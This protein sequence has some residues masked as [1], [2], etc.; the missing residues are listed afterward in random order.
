MHGYLASSPDSS[1]VSTADPALRLVHSD[2]RLIDGA[3]APLGL[4]LLDALEA[5]AAEREGLTRGDAFAVLLRRNLVTGATVVL[6]RD[7]L[8]SA[9]PIGADWIHDEWLAMIAAALDA[10]PGAFGSSQSR[11]ST[12]D[13]TAE[14]RSGRADRPWP[15]VGRAC[16]NHVSSGRRA[17]SA[18]HGNWPSVC[19]N[20]A[21]PTVDSSRR[22]T[23]LAHEARRAGPAARAARAGTAGGRPRRA[24][25]LPSLQS[26]LDRCPA[27]SRAAGREEGA[28]TRVLVL[29]GDP[30]GERM[31]GPAIR[32]WNI[33]LELLANGH[34]VR[35]VSTAAAKRDAT[36]VTL[37]QVRPGDDRAFRTHERWAEVIVVQGYGLGQFASLRRTDRYL[38]VDAYDPIH[39]ELLE[40]GREL[41][42]ATWKHRVA[43][44]RDALNDQLRRADLVLC[45]SERQRLFYLG[46]LA[47]LGRINPATYVDDPQLERLLALVPF[48]LEADPPRPAPAI[49]DVVPGV[50]SDSRILIWG[51]GVYDWFDPLT[52]IRAVAALAQRMPELR[53]FFLGTRH[54]RVDDMGIVRDSYD[55]AVALGVEGRQVIFNDQWV[56]YDERGAYLLEADL[57]V[58]THHVHVETEFAFRTRILDYLWA[59]LP[60]V[61]T[62]GDGFAELVRDEELGIVVPPED[63]IALASA[64]ET[65]LT[66]AGAVARARS[67]VARVRDRFTWSV[68]VAPLV[69]FVAAPRHA[70]DYVAGRGGMGAAGPRPARTAGPLHDLRM[71]LHHLRHSGPREVLRRIRS[72]RRPATGQ[73]ADDGS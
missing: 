56:P 18:E 22:G 49:R 4:T 3:G 69:S 61:V 25:P 67:G 59:G 21:C 71:S 57:G 70:S 8:T 16:G 32:A 34:E 33:S 62:D 46:H 13:S 54:P 1:R 63:E 35:L 47:S 41:P 15:T 60:M 27:R 2:A 10:H 7:L 12:T 73:R 42:D 64:I 11:S 19:A 55:L 66:D 44:A 39:L 72:R 48:G 6:R 14:T 38:V 68:V 5:T 36:P 28:M 9:L 30:V 24:R 43:V 20:S 53:M 26:G 58:S 45:A 23:R 29:T 65:L 52:L 31:A 50:D 17:S 40:Q 51:G 37:V